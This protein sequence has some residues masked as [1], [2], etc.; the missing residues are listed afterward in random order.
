MSG[1]GSR[2]NE[3]RSPSRTS[4]N[5]KIPSEI[6]PG[7]VGPRSQGTHTP[8]SRISV[9][10]SVDFPGSECGTH[11]PR[12]SYIS[13]N[14]LSEAESHSLH[15]GT[16]NEKE[17]VHQTAALMIEK[18]WIGYRDK[19]MFRLLKHSVCAAE[20]SLSYEILR[21]V[22]PKE[23]E[24][25]SDKSQQVRVR[26][27][28][29]GAE[30]PPM[31]F[32]KIFINSN[33]QKVK[34]MSGRKTIKP[35]TEAAED[36]LRQMGNRIF[37]DQ[38]LQD[39][40]RQRQCPVTDEI[41]VTTLK[42]YMQYLSNLDESPAYQGGKENYW[43]KLTLDVLP[44]HTIFF[45]VV[46][47]AYN[48]RL[49]P[50][51]K[52]EIP[53]LLSRPVTQEVQVRHIKAISKMRTPVYPFGPFP[54]PSKSKLSGAVSHS[55]MSSRRSKQAKQ[56]ALKMR[57]VYSRELGDEEKGEFMSEAGD[58]EDYFAKLGGDETEMF[59]EEEV[60]EMGDEDWDKEANK[61]YEWT[62]ELSFNDDIMQTPL[63]GV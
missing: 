1:T 36:S 52:E 48:N 4:I 44:R 27:R 35:A 5:V 43:R 3:L 55:Q 7:Q 15:H 30:F 33:G 18:A 47:F 10:Q 59:E 6:V 37:Y 56:R 63:M 41:D 29:G 32:F 60:G 39:T 26:F 16:I 57:K 12:T 34:Y 22:S 58:M 54:T 20:N 61:L 11:G 50:R 25:L 38:I 13:K 14:T 31:I 17:L 2:E 8:E 24:F 23:A 19:Q 21:K 51:L 40:I 42:D 9:P 45:D 28:F 62:Q 53:I 46:D 49:T